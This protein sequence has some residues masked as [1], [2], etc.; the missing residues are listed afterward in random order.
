MPFPERSRILYKKNPLDQVVCQL[1]FPPLLKIDAEVPAQFQEKIRKAY[2]NFRESA[3]VK[4]EIP[5]ELLGQIPPELFNQSIQSPFKNYE[6]ASEDNVWKI[7]LTRTFIAL[8]TKKYERWEG[9]KEQLVIPLKALTEIYRP[10]YFTRIGLRYIDIIKRSEL[11]L[12]DVDWNELLQPF[13]LGLVSSPDVGKFVEKF[14][15]RYEIKLSDNESFAR[16]LTSFVEAKNN[17][18]VGFVID[19]DFYNTN[20]TSIDD[21]LKKLDFFNSRGSRLIQWCITERL[22]KAME[23]VAL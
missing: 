3:E 12:S 7:N 21:A 22:H 15:S 13:I 20:K 18:E 5:T 10:D 23:P 4:F 1:R 8:T 11:G 9:F 6:F 14:E 19:S 2:P 17:G 16:I